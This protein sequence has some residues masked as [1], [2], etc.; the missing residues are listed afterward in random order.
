[1]E[2][3]KY[4][5]VERFGTVETNGIDNGMCYVFPKIDGTNAQ[6]WWCNVLCAG[7][8]NRQLELDNDNQGFM[9]WAAS[10]EN[11]YAFFRAYPHLRLFGEWL[12]PH[13]LNTYQKTAWRK[14]YVFDVMLGEYYMSYDVY[15]PMLDEF[16]I[17]YIPPICRVENPGY[18]RLVAQLEKNGYLIEDGQGTGE[19]VVIKNYEYRN[20]FGRQ[21]WAK[22]VKNEFKAAHAKVKVTELSEIKI[23]EQAIVD[24]YV[25]QSLCEKEHAK[26]NNETGWS[27]KNILQLLNVVYYCLITEESWNFIKEHKRPVI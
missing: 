10:Q 11:I 27:S 3:I 4:Q 18:D 1:M 7:S 5:H 26:I 13:T 15:K 21:T 20:K 2:F 6:L 23:I 19:G 24:K 14:F 17:E 22:I 8:R 16:D 25:T 12:V 9:E